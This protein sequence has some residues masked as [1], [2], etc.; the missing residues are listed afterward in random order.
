MKT[1]LYNDKGVLVLYRNGLPLTCPFTNRMLVPVATKLIQDRG[2]VELRVQTC[3]SACALFSLTPVPHEYKSIGAMINPAHI[4]TQGCR[5]TLYKMKA[6][7][8]P[9]EGTIEMLEE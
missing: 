7:N 6:E 9:K 4:I 5:P 1:E 8:L 3:S 2:Q